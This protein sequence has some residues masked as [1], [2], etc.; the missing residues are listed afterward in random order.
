MRVKTGSGPAGVEDVS[1]RRSLR[2][3]KPVQYKPSMNLCANSDDDDGDSG[4]LADFSRPATDDEDTSLT[5]TSSSHSDS[6]QKPKSAEKRSATVAEDGAIHPLAKR[7]RAAAAESQSRGASVRAHSGWKT[8]DGLNLHL[9]PINDIASIFADMT[10]RA[11]G[12]GLRSALEHLGTRKLN[13]AT[14]CSG[15][16][17]PMLA[18]EMICDRMRCIYPSPK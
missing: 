5:S 3:K 12:L 9:P 16:E 11:L 7:A 10:E 18:L 13:V 8:T 15:T 14:M 4:S 17:S 6:K 1:A 2:S